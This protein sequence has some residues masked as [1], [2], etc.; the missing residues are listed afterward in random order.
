MASCFTR[1]ESGWMLQPFLHLQKSGDAL[2]WAAQ[3]S[4]G[5]PI[6]EGVPECGDVPRGDMVMGMV[7]WGKV[8]FER[9]FPRLIQAGAHPRQHPRCHR[10]QC[11]TLLRSIMYLQEISITS[12]VAASPSASQSMRAPAALVS[13]HTHTHRG[14]FAIPSSSPRGKDHAWKT[15]PFCSHC[16]WN[17]RKKQFSMATT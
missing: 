9:S 6:P 2:A 7:G 11:C 8:G 17:G 15:S 3:G 5:V 13:S 14:I 16:R 1:A 4:V 12:S 10:S